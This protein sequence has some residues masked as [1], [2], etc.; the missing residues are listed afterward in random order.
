MAGKRGRPIVVLP[1]SAEE[2]DYLEQQVRHHRI[3]ALLLIVVALS[4]GA[5]TISDRSP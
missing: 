4:F 5:P 3:L 2:R 1:L